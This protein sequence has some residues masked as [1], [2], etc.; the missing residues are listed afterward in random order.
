MNNPNLQ[1]GNWRIVE[2]KIFLGS[3]KFNM[4][5]FS[6]E[7]GEGQVML[8]YKGAFSQEVLADFSQKI[9]Y[10]YRHMPKA[11]SK[12]N[13]AFI[14]LAQ[15]VA[16]HSAEQNKLEIHKYD[17]GVGMVV[18]HE[19][20]QSIRLTTA[21]M[22]RLDDARV[23]AERCAQ[24]NQLSQ[25]ELRIMKKQLRSASLSSPKK[26]ANIGLVQVAIKSKSQLYV[27]VDHY[28]ESR[29]FLMIS[30]GIAKS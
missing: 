27:K 13:S 29:A 26:G 22:A 30:T 5:D 7:Q 25:D 4:F 16:Y 9:R 23:I 1:C 24:I 11:L 3:M 18:I 15:N 28:S 14:E 17:K 6:L 20:E 8:S 2:T 10:M 21:N 12:L 19:D